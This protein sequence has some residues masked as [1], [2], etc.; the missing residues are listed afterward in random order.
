MYRLP[1]TIEER[2]RWIEALPNTNLTVNNNSVICELHWPNKFEGIKLRGGKLR[3]K[4]PPSVWPVIPLSQIPSASPPER[5]T[6]RASCSVRNVK[7]DELEA[8]QEI[9]TI[10]YATLK[11]KKMLS[12]PSCII[13][14]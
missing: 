9:D 7:G 5:I 8:F 2:E 10:S 1:R 13:H 4:N 3:P 11:E 14:R 12:I 6:E